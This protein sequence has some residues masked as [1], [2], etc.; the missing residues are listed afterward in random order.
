[1]QGAAHIQSQPDHLAFVI[2][3]FQP[4][5]QGRQ[6]L[7]ADIDIPADAVV[8]LNRPQILAVHHVGVFSQLLHE[9]IFPHQILHP[10]LKMGGDAFAVIALGIQ[11]RYFRLVLGD[12]QLFQRRPLHSHIR[13]GSL[14][15][16]HPAKAALAQ[17]ANNLPARETDVVKFLGHP[18][19]L[20][21]FFI[22]AHHIGFFNI[23]F[24]NAF[25]A[26]S[27]PYSGWN[28][29][30]RKTSICDT[31][32]DERDII[33]AVISESRPEKAVSAFGDIRVF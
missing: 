27:Y 29:R 28:E 3:V 10:F 30:C 8:V 25:A 19:S 16:I 20:H 1:M 2:P 5:L 26:I 23:G 24:F 17:L 14:N 33:Q 15:F 22:L 9:G 13:Q 32:D 31:A 18:T 21:F 4:E 7:H 12:R 11:L 6:Q